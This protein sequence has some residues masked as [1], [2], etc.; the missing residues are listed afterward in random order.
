MERRFLNELDE[1]KVAINKMASLVDEQVD[2]SFKILE[3]GSTEFKRIKQ[4]DREVDALDNLVMAKCENL[5]ALFQPVAGDLR[6]I[7]AAIKVGNQLERCGDIAVNIVQRIDKIENF[8]ELVSDLDILKMAD[9]ARMM[10]KDAITAFVNQDTKLAEATYEKDDIVDAFNKSIFNQIVE[11]I[12]KN[13]DITEPCAHLI[14]LLRHIER[15]ADHATNIAEDVIF[16][17]ENEIISHKK[18]LKNFHS[19]SQD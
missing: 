7:L 1:L 4:K 14:V 9:I 16:L 5:L 10:V 6:F 19:P 15:L 18:K 8:Y 3:D 17:T 11:K 12:K 2:S 13:P